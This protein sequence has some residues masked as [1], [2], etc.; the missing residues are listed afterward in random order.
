MG[1]FA[2]LERWSHK[3][4]RSQGQKIMMARLCV[5]LRCQLVGES[6]VKEDLGPDA[7]VCADWHVLL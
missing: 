4:E 3:Q 5:K 1:A 6:P 2:K 7:P